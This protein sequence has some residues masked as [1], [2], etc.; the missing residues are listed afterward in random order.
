MKKLFIIFTLFLFWVYGCDSCRPPVSTYIVKTETKID[1][2]NA[3]SYY[4]T[5]MGYTQFYMKGNI[6]AVYHGDVK[7]KILNRESSWN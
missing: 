7:V 6:I 2:I 5:K 4:I 3:T 1:T